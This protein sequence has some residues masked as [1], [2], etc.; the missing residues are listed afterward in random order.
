V[1][2]KSTQAR[3]QNK[4]PKPRK[5]FDIEVEGWARLQAS[6]QFAQISNQ[7]AQQRQTSIVDPTKPPINEGQQ[8]LQWLALEVITL[9]LLLM[10]LMAEAGLIQVATPELVEQLRK[11]LQENDDR[12]NSDLPNNTSS[13]DSLVSIVSNDP[14]SNVSGVITSDQKKD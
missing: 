4:T 6:N 11:Q 2:S 14:S 7:L 1:S 3:K 12:T 13:D 5:L 8:L 10:Q 9:R